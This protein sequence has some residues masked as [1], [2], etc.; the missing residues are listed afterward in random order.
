MFWSKLGLFFF[1]S[2]IDG[3]ENLSIDRKSPHGLKVGLPIKY[4]YYRLTK[5]RS[6]HVNLEIPLIS[7]VKS[8]QGIPNSQPVC[9]G[10]KAKITNY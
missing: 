5:I 7:N 3:Q 2:P 4:V 1:F 9:G 10:I 8:E 6:K